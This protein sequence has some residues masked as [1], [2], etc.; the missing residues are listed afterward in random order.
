MLKSLFSEPTI[1]YCEVATKGLIK[2][3]YYAFS[4]LAFLFVGIAILLKGNGS[5]LSKAFG[6]IAILVGLL[7]F[8]YDSSY[9]YITQLIDL[10]GM[11]LLISFLLYLNLSVL[12]KNKILIT[13]IQVIAMLL[14]LMSIIVFQAYSGDIVFGIFVLLYVISEIYLLMVNKHKNYMMWV[15]PLAVFLIGFTF[16]ILDASKIY[17]VNFGLLNGRAI[18]HFLNAIVIY[19]LYDYYRSQELQG[20]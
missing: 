13:T 19:H 18:F 5:A 16:W 3:P 20:S 6:Y 8:A 9:L 7:S 17:C 11:L 10:T 15:L 2:R 1:Q 4:N 12:Y 14:G